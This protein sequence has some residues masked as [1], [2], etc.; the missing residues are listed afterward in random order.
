LRILIT[1]AGGLVGRALSDY[2]IRLGDEV[3]AY[4]RSGL[5]IA[6]EAHV[7]LIVA[8]AKPDVVINC[9]AWTDVDGCETDVARCRAV[10]EIGPENL[11]RASRNADA[12]LITISTDYVFDGTKEGFY[13]QRDNPNPLSVYARA[14]FNGERRAQ[15]AHARTIVV[16]TGFVFGRGGKNFLS[17]AIDR[18]RRGEKVKAI[19]DAWGTPTYAHHLAG[20]LRELAQL[21]LPG[22]FH[23]VNSG[24]GT[25]Y[26]DFA[27]KAL[28][29]AGCDLANLE[30][31]LLESVN[32]PAPRPKNSRLKCLLSDA[33]GLEP[34]P[35][36]EEG[37][38]QFVQDTTSKIHTNA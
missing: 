27:S 12:L 18:I 19:A 36:W 32:R 23:I 1:G 3:L 16:R 22:V 24:D 11:A 9:A 38:A 33:V 25:N 8:E 21:D 37:L 7:E 29:L 20:R 34:L 2:C 31:V 10:N 26:A 30:V 28:Q 17:T 6:N 5:D 4:D 15:S 13:T 35:S 14:K